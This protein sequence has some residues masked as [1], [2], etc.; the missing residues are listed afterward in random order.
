MIDVAIGQTNL[1]INK[2]FAQFRGLIEKCS[3]IDAETPVSCEDLHGFWD[4]MNIQINNLN[5]RFENLDNLKANNWQ[6]IIPEVKK[7]VTKKKNVAPKN[8]KASACLREAIQAARKKK[9]TEKENNFDIAVKTP[10]NKRCSNRISMVKSVEKSK[11]QSSPGL[12]M[13]KV[14][15][16]AK[17]VEVRVN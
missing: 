11:R 7:V 4:M 1:L 12:M 5:K 15:Q 2:K 6:E 9:Q 14:A 8:V 10:I 17:S 13:M 3:E 16:F